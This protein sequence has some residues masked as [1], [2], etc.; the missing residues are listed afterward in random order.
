MSLD[1]LILVG[2]GGATDLVVHPFEKY[3]TPSIQTGKYPSGR[4]KEDTPAW[5]TDQENSM[6]CF[7]VYHCRP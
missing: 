3:C 5:P 1:D 2:S 7:A 4:Q 6:H